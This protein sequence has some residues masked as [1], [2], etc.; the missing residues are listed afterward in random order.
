MEQ[1]KEDIASSDIVL[2]QEV[3]SEIDKIFTINPNP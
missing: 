3:I 2:S 1:L